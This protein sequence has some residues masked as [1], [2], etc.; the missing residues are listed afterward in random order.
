[1]SISRLKQSLGDAAIIVEPAPCSRCGVCGVSDDGFN[2]P[3]TFKGTK[4]SIK[5]YDQYR[6]FWNSLGKPIWFLFLA[7]LMANVFSLNEPKSII[8]SLAGFVLGYLNCNALPEL[9]LEKSKC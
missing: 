2:L 9:F 7:T 6:I 3:Q 4:I 1:M 8:A 5:V